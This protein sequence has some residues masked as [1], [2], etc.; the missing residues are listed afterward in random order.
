MMRVI[1]YLCSGGVCKKY[2]VFLGGCP[3]TPLPCTVG[4]GHRPGPVWQAIK[5]G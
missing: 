2:D 4:P 3:P 5:R 1:G